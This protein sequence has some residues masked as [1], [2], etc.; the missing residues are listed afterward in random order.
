MLYLISR[1]QQIINRKGVR[2]I[3]KDINIDIKINS[4]NRK[5][6]EKVLNAE[7]KNGQTININQNDIL[8]T[9]RQLVLCECDMCGKDFQ[10]KKTYITTDVTLCSKECRT[11]KFILNNPNPTKDKI[12]T[13]CA[14]CNK[15]VLVSDAKY[16]NQENILCSRDCYA[17]F[18]SENYNKDKIYNYNSVDSKCACCDKEIIVSMF[19]T[20]RNKHW[21]CS[22]ECYYKFRSDNYSEFYYS[23]N[24]R[25]NRPESSPEKIVR[26][27]LDDNKIEYKQEVGFLRKY[28]CD[29]YLTDLKI[30]LEV[31]GDYWHVNP[32]IYDVLG[33]DVSKKTI[34][35][36]QEAFIQRDKKK[37]DDFI[38][39]D[40]DYRII[41]ES[42]VHEN[43]NLYMNEI[44][45]KESVTTTRNAPIN[46]G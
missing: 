29:F 2:N 27:W 21:F 32:N 23:P 22:N 9:S 20:K 12:V 4:N 31:Y 26:K 19:T 39:R 44:L 16:K 43:V 38:M 8:L 7:L 40:L 34:N 30:I 17:L 6:Y 33:N 3:I 46:I 45:N 11:Q 14:M 10:R 18:R 41:W 15:E 37:E 25:L 28:Y 42:E 5:K 1:E 36:Q 13:C 35:E 24:N